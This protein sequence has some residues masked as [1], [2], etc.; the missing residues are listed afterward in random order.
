MS[1]ISTEKY[2]VGRLALALVYDFDDWLKNKKDADRY[3][4]SFYGNNWQ[5]LFYDELNCPKWDASSD[6]KVY[7]KKIQSHLPEYPM[8]SR[9][10]D[11]YEY[12]WFEGEEIEQLRKEC[13]ELQSKLSKSS[14]LEGLHSIILAC[15]EALASEA[16]LVMLPD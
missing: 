13:A 3:V 1:K 10:V 2:I 14:A 16:T 8:L 6:I 11:M 12:Y 5:A 7:Q 9:I 4:E 15:D